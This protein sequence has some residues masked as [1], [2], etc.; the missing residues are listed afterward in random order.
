[1]AT[2]VQAV[3]PDLPSS[4]S[5]LRD[6]RTRRHTVA[7]REERPAGRGGSV[8][9]IDRRTLG[10]YP[11][12]PPGSLDRQAQPRRAA[13]GRADANS[14]SFLGPVAPDWPTRISG[15]GALQLTRHVRSRGQPP[16]TGS[17]RGARA[18]GL[19]RCGNKPRCGRAESD[20]SAPRLHARRG[21]SPLSTRRLL[22]SGKEPD[23]GLPPA[24]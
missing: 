22:D 8:L 16:V 13:D 21:S 11:A 1:M 20:Q 4:P 2:V 7:I 5:G 12:L 15:P 10:T 9:P 19:A 24:H 17:P 3:Y 6:R 14:G 23:G 18:R